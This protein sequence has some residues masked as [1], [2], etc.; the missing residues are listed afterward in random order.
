MATIGMSNTGDITINGKVFNLDNLVFK[1]P[2][3]IKD[4]DNN[5]LL[6]NLGFAKYSDYLNFKNMVNVDEASVNAKADKAYVDS[7]FLNKANKSDILLATEINNIQ[8]IAP[9][10]VGPITIQNGGTASYT[11]TDYDTNLIYNITTDI[12]TVNYDGGNTFDIV[13]NSYTV[14]TNGT[15]NVYATEP[16]KIVSNP[17]TINVIVSNVTYVADQLLSNSDYATN[18]E[19]NNLFQY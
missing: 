5:L 9:S 15:V 3:N 11:I 4:I 17:K 8:T 6:S 2:G 12:G 16:G 13:A 1:A 7:I 14:S 19:Y 18:V 10:V